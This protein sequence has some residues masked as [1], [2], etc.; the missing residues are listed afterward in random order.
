[1]PTDLLLVALKGRSVDL[2]DDEAV[3]ALAKRFRVSEAAMR[4]RLDALG[5]VG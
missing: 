2:E 5:V 3:A 1:M 4:H